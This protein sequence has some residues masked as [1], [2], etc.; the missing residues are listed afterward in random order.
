MRRTTVVSTLGA[1]LLPLSLLALV[2]GPAEAG[3]AAPE[4][5]DRAPTATGTSDND[6]FTGTGATDVWSLLAGD[7]Q[8]D[9]GGGVDYICGNGGADFGLYGGAG[10]DRI[11]GGD[12]ADL[13]S[14]DSADTDFAG[15]DLLIGGKGNDYLVG[16]RGADVLRGGP[17]DD[18]LDLIGEDQFQAGADRVFGGGGRDVID[19]H[20]DG[21]VDVIDC[22]PGRDLVYADRRDRVRDNCEIVRHRAPESSANRQARAYLG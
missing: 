10:N 3:V 19:E 18:S 21:A 11:D 7:D 14:G 20:S 6:V 13:L 17:G 16:D 9:S 1:L 8:G 5:F 4:C 22:G 2:T 12:G 15:E